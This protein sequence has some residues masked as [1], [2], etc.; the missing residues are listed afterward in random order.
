MA[1]RPA[2]RI[3]KGGFRKPN[4]PRKGER[5]ILPERRGQ[6]EFAPTLQSPVTGSATRRVIARRV[7]RANQEVEVLVTG[8]VREAAPGLC[9]HYQKRSVPA[10]C[11][12]AHIFF[13]MS[14][15]MKCDV[16]IYGDMLDSEKDSSDFFWREGGGGGKNIFIYCVKDQ[17]ELYL[18]FPI[19]LSLVYQQV[20][21]GISGQECA[22]GGVKLR[23]LCFRSFSQE[24][25]VEVFFLILVQPEV[26]S[27]AHGS[28][29]GKEK[30]F[31][32]KESTLKLKIDLTPGCK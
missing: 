11:Y 25:F 30:M 1:W 15:S 19:A 9:L 13:S 7:E 29:G 31:S 2:T 3:P 14:F 17:R 12:L 26:P 18:D 27:L 20:L 24:C 22:L 32:T 4:C 23:G 10:F 16:N 5:R 8:S 21:T 28:E 6:P